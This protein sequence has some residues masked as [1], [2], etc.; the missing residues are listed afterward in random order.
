MRF[1]FVLMVLVVAACSGGGQAATRAP[2]TAAPAE[3]PAIT[4]P[5]SLRKIEGL[6]VITF[7]MSYDDETLLIDKPKSKFKR[8]VKSIAYSAQFSEVAGST[9]L[10]VVLAKVSKGGA[11]E[12]LEST[13]VT[14]SN[15][16]FD[17]FAN[18]ADLASIVNNKKG[19]YM[20]RYLWEGTVLAEGTFELTAK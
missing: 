5:P 1:L 7:G 6:G 19:K 8:N 9:T 16:E 10:T 2:N 15:P 13:D 18:E 14:I 11:E 3:E 17:L 12:L 20:F 4:D